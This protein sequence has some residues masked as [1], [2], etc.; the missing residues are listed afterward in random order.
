MCSYSRSHNRCKI[1]KLLTVYFKSSGLAAKAFDTLN[2]LGL[3]MSQKSAYDAIKGLCDRLQ[4]QLHNDIETYP[5]FGTHDN[6]NLPFRVYEQR[7]HNQSHF[8]SGT[9]AT[10]II[11]KDPT[12]V[13][14]D[15]QAFQ[16]QRAL[17]AKNPITY[18]DILKLER[19]AAPR[20]RVRTVHRV[21]RFLID[22]P[23]FDFDSYEHKK[24]KVFDGPASRH[25]IPVGAQHRTTQYMLNTVH[26]EEASYDGNDRVLAEWRKQ[27]GFDTPEKEK[28]LASKLLL[29][30]G[31]QLTVSRLRG[32]KKF[33]CMDLNS[34]DRMDFLVPIFGWFHALLAVQH[35]LHNQYYGTRTSLGLQHAFDNLKRKGLHAPSVQ[36]DFFY[37]FQDALYHIAEAHFRDLF[38]IVGKVND[39]KDLR[40]R[41]PQELYDIAVAIVTD[42]ASSAAMMKIAPEKFVKDKK[43]NSKLGKAAPNS[44]VY[45]GDDLLYQ[46]T[47]FLRDILTY[48]DL[49]ESISAGDVGRMQDLLPRLLFR[50]AG[51]RNKNYTIEIL[52]LLQGLHREWPDDLKC[53]FSVSTL[54][55][56]LLF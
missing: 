33:R 14:P 42:Y 3:T 47:Q 56:H 54:S 48:I 53:V 52:E 45:T 36:G 49:D 24:D 30:V 32:L 21:L 43:K 26:I 18:R 22:S 23:D 25:Q 4:K 55:A 9:A 6:I 11:V 19:D 34:F 7:L 31:D 2:A 51:G 10:I 28:E 27:L 41:T 44:T 1:P 35:S 37:H 13:R 38:S 5:W 8:D 50:F 46:T 15:L 12:A 17:G 39:L 29:W 16:R 20:L 40:S